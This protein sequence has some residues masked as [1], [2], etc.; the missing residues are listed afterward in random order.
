MR[1]AGDRCPDDLLARSRRGPLSP[2]ER[3]ALDAHLGVCG[4]CRAAA[5]LGALG[6]DIPDG[7]FAGDDAVVA[8]LAGRVVARAGRGS[9]RARPAALAAGLVV[10]VLAGARPR[11]PRW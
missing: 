10:A 11:S 6:D 2:V 4:L 8:R 7:P 9:R 3:R 5:A 1:S